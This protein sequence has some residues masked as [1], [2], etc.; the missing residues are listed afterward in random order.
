MNKNY[1][2]GFDITSGAKQGDVL[3]PTLF[4][5]FLNDLVTGIKDLGTEW[6]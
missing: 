2:Q 4:F 5:M 6:I 1:T 3:S